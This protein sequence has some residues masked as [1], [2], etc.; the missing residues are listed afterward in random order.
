MDHQEKDTSEE[1]D[2]AEVVLADGVND[3]LRKFAES[4]FK[5]RQETLVEVSDKY[6]PSEY[7]VVMT[8]RDYKHTVGNS[9]YEYKAFEPVKVTKDVE[10]ILADVGV[11]FTGGLT[12]SEI[13]RKKALFEKSRNVKWKIK[14]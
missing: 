8:I 2:I 4:L 3:E 10:G 6:L 13:A 14:L 9:T 12:S 5:D 7:V 11:L 1:D